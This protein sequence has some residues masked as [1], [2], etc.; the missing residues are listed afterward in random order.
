[1]EE[2]ELTLYQTQKCMYITTILF[3]TNNQSDNNH[4]HQYTFHSQSKHTKHILTH[5][6]NLLNDKNLTLGPRGLSY[7]FRIWVHLFWP[8]KN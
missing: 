7:C 5:Y 6:K 1:M 3:K 2:E 4:Y 8:I